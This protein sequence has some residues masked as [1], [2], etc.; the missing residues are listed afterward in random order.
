M[1]GVTRAAVRMPNSTDG[2]EGRRP[3]GHLRPVEDAGRY[4]G[5][6]LR[7]DTNGRPSIPMEDQRDH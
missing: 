6:L 5:A 3:R 1:A 7:H 4:A 2:R